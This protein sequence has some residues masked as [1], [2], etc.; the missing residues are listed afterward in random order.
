MLFTRSIR[1]KMMFGL[2]LILAMLLTLYFSAVSGLKSYREL[3]DQF[4]FSMLQAPLQADLVKATSKL[5][6]P[7]ADDLPEADEEKAKVAAAYQRREFQSQLQTAREGIRTFQEKLRNLP[8]TEAVLARRPATAELLEGLDQQLIQLEGLQLKLDNPA[9]RQEVSREM[10]QRVIKLHEKAQE[11]PYNGDGLHKTLNEADN[12]YR[13]RLLLIR[14][15]AGIVVLLF[16]LLLRYGYS[17]VF[18]PLRTLHQGAQRVAQGDF[19]YRVDINTNDEVAELAAAF[20][21]MTARFQEITRD[22]DREVRERSKQLVRSDRLANLGRFAAGIAHEI[23]NPLT[24]IAAAAE[25]LEYRQQ[26]K[27]LLRHASS[28]GA[29]PGRDPANGRVDDSQSPDA[30]DDGTARKYLQ[31]IQ[32]EAFRCQGITLKILDFSRG[33]DSSRTV[34]DLTNIV[35]EVLSL[36]EL[37]GQYRNR[38]I[39]FTHE[40]P[41]QIEINGPEIKQVV[42]NLVTNALE[43]ME[44]GQKLRISLTDQTDQVYITLEDEG[45]GMTPEVIENLF[46]PFFT[47]RKDGRGTGLGLSISNRIITDHGGRIEVSSDGPGRGSTFIVHLPRVLALPKAAA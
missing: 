6:A 22:L 37:L 4:R 40:A 47:R 3:K 5:L 43:S 41:C 45:C 33:Q 11:V 21:R 14:W 30:D 12:V 16:L 31:I 35:S 17:G 10:L 36:V 29:T 42:L 20:N 25:A 26:E 15:A 27:D 34:C 24:S 2:A 44:T 46:E 1:R 19:D 28:V 23:N 9:G 13:S 18:A 8:P 38:T 7:L 39:E 32:E